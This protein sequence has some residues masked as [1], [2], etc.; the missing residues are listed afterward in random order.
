MN[1]PDGTPLVEHSRWRRRLTAVPPYTLLTIIAL[2]V[3]GIPFVFLKQSEWQT[4]YV[5]AAKKFCDGD[6][7]YS[8]GGP[9]VYPPFM[10]LT[11]VPFSFLPETLSRFFWFLC[12]AVAMVACFRAVW[13]LGGAEGPYPNW[14]ALRSE[15]LIVFLA[16]GCGSYYVAD[17]FAHQQTDLVIAALIFQGCLALHEQRS[18]R[19]ALLLGLAAACKGTPLLFL[20]YLIWRGRPLAAIAMLSVAVSVNLLPDLY[21]RPTTSGSWLLEWWRILVAPQLSGDRGTGV[22][23]SEVIYNQS[24]AGAMNRWTQTTW[25]W[26][27]SRVTVVPRD[28]AMASADLHRT[29][30]LLQ[31]GLLLGAFLVLMHRPF[32]RLQEAPGSGGVSRTA[33]ECSVIVV[34]MLLLSPMSS[35]PHFCTLLLP[36]FCLARLAA[37]HGYIWRGLLAV[38]IVGGLLANKDLVKGRIY[39]LTLWYGSVMASALILGILSCWSLL[40]MSRERRERILTGERKAEGQLQQAA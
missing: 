38:A 10:M 15:H 24:L 3:L 7:L 4:V 6:G 25:L 37:K 40:S 39:T 35:K 30:Q 19:A 9:Y 34:L 8:V 28:E 14:S 16:L 29:M 21:Y 33:L 18:L 31:V 5:P 23:A 1:L 36:G 20:P 11:A 13:R 27:A 26:D 32:R 22:W 2:I 12:N 17:S